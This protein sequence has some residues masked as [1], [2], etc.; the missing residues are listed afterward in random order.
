MIAK[1]IEISATSPT[2]FDDAV[3]DGIATAAKTVRHIT[4]CWVKD[5]N[6]EVEEGKIKAFRVNL[7]LTFMLE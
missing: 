5:M 1:V 2:S 4:G 3:K 6:V 7:S